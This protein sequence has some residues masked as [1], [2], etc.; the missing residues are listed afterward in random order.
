M[1]EIQA[2]Q[3]S[4]RVIKRARG[5]TTDFEENQSLVTTLVTYKACG[6]MMVIDGKRALQ[7]YPQEICALLYTFE[8]IHLPDLL[9]CYSLSGFV[10]LIT[11]GGVQ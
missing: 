3:A 11:L 2:A 4:L 9:S 1:R 7:S 6:Q 8:K 10:R 5:D